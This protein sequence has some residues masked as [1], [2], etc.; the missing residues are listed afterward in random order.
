LHVSLYCP[1]LSRLQL[2]FPMTLT[3]LLLDLAFTHASTITLQAVSNSDN[4]NK[5][6]YTYRLRLVYPRLNAHCLSWKTLKK[7]Q[8][9]HIGA[10]FLGRRAYT[11][12]LDLIIVL[13][14]DSSIHLS[15]YWILLGCSRVLYAAMSSWAGW[16]TADAMRMVFPAAS[17][18]PFRPRSGD[19]N[20]ICR[21]PHQKLI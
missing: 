6:K 8:L 9:C 14:L 12:F 17:L 1:V 7:L 11:K 3:L 18:H 13:R 21:I 19:L 20:H 2:L 10:H 16:Q 4:L 15:I 5:L